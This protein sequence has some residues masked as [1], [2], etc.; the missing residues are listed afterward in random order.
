VNR[1]S[2]HHDVSRL[3]PLSRFVARAYSKTTLNVT[4]REGFPLAS[5]FEHPLA[6]RRKNRAARDATV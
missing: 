1:E 5:G 3:A 6:A 4:L 2:R